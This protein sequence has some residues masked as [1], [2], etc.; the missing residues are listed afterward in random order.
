MLPK[1]LQ[2]IANHI[3][4]Q[5]NDEIDKNRRFSFKEKTNWGF[6]I[7]GDHETASKMARWVTIIGMGPDVS[8]EFHVGQVVLVDALKWTKLVEYDGVEFA[9]TDETH[10]LAV[11][12]DT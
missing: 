7:R 10:I 6:E 1:D 8:D 3:L 2:P 4:F 9:R 11:D 5:F 12:D